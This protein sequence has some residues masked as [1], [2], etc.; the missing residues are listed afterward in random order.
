MAAETI[1]DSLFLFLTVAQQGI[2]QVFC[3]TKIRNI[4][5]VCFH[6]VVYVFTSEK[7]F[8]VAE[9]PSNHGMM[10]PVQ[11]TESSKVYPIVKK[12]AIC[13]LSVQG[14]SILR[15]MTDVDFG[16]EGH[17]SYTA[18]QDVTATKN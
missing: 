12:Y 10:D 5:F 16:S 1:L 2:L 7:E 9:G 3:N 11:I 14:L 18:K 17:W 6:F 8:I 13:T 15:T 4:A